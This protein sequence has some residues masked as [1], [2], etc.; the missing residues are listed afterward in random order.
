M[1]KQVEQLNNEGAELFLVG[2]FKEAKLKYK[3][4]LNISPNY[5]TTLNNLG[6]IYLQEKKFK[7]AEKNFKAAFSKKE[8]A[9][10]MLNLGH[11]YANQNKQNEAETSYQKSIELNPNSI[12]AW[13]SLATLFQY[14]KEFRKSVKTWKYIIQQL[15][16]DNYFRIQLAKAYIKLGE[17]KNALAVLD[18]AS[19]YEKHQ[20]L[21]W[22]YSAL[23]HLNTKN[24]GWAKS[25]IK[26]SLA[27]QP[28]QEDFRALLATIHLA[29][30]EFN[31]A[32]FQWDA[33]LKLNEYNHKVRIDKAITLMSKH[34]NH[35]A[36]S[37]FEKVLQYDETNYKA[38]FY[39]AVALLEMNKSKSTVIK[40]LNKLKLEN[41]PYASK[42]EILL[43]KIS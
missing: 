42:A 32:I 18:E 2:K 38:Q 13:K 3:Q 23:I 5:P 26:K 8:K 16:N 14:K 41:H 21:I 40:I 11:A 37:E 33:I 28:N 4:A 35:E 36:L 30:S 20:E 15:D 17:Y 24:F 29:L 31:E 10:Y 43:T 9:T 7:Q 1:K 27:I 34:Y 39:K 6:M 12:V 25:S 19:Q 22:Y